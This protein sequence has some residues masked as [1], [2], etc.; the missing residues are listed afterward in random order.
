MKAIFVF[1]IALSLAACS[2]NNTVEI[3]QKT[4]MKVNPVFD[5]GKVLHGEEIAAEFVVTNEGDYPLV[6]SE[7]KGSC[8]CTVA[9]KPEEPI[10]PGKSEKIRATVRTNSGPAGKL[11]KEVRIVAN[12]E[13]SITVLHIE[14]DVFR[15]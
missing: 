8:S 5:A 12:T 11:T 2:E 13:P 1:F 9:E 4:V 7:V 3:G 6:I 14:A 10:P 15:K